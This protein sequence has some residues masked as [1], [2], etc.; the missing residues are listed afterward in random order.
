MDGNAI[1]WCEGNFATTSGKTAHGLA[2]FTRRY[3]VTA[4]I[5]SPLAGRDAGAVLDGKPSGIPLVA[6]LAAAL[7][8]APATHLVIG[9]APDGGRLPPEGRRAVLAA[10]AG[11]L[12][13]DSG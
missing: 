9:L 7:A 11:G 2:R 13:V 1:V 4:V 5:D 3:K 12:N 8:C 6:D 10:I